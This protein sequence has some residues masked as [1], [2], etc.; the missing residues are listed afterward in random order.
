M[1]NACT[2]VDAKKKMPVILHTFAESTQIFSSVD[3]GKES[4]V[5]CCRCKIFVLPNDLGM[6]FPKNT[7]DLNW[8]IALQ[9]FFYP[10]LLAG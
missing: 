2:D 4:I 9:N 3:C 1:L 10:R 7:E 5:R 8:N 6:L